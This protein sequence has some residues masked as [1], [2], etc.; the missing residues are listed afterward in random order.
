MNDKIKHPFQ[1]PEDFF[2]EFKSEMLGEIELHINSKRQS[3]YKKIIL[4]TLK[5][6]AIVVFAFLIGRYSTGIN[7]K[8]SE[9]PSVETVFNQV[10]EDEIIAFVIEDELFEK[11]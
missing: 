3:D 1:V 10:A 11:Q 6:A 7:H 8:K 2:E 4:V 9:L 5:Y